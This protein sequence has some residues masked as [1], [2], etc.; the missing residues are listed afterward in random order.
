MGGAYITYK[1]KN[2][3]NI[4]YGNTNDLKNNITELCRVDWKHT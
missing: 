4:Q 3:Y 2:E 1:G